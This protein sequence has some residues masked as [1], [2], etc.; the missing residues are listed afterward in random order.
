MTSVSSTT[1]KDLVCRLVR[2]I[3][4]TSYQNSQCFGK[5][6]LQHMLHPVMYLALSQYHVLRRLQKGI[7]NL[8][9]FI[10]YLMDAW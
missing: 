10:L 5:R 6:E 7:S 2:A 3:S 1:R 9:V 8:Q 4:N